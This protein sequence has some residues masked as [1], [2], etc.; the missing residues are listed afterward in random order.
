MTVEDTIGAIRLHLKSAKIQTRDRGGHTGFRRFMALW[1]YNWYNVVYVPEG[2]LVF[3]EPMA[4]SKKAKKYV[5][6]LDGK[7]IWAKSFNLVE[8]DSLNRL[9]RYIKHKRKARGRFV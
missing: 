6:I 8:P 5:S 1:D 2:P 9:V 4:Y 7:R 3:A